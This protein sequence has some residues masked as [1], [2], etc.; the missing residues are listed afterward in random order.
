MKIKIRK[1]KETRNIGIRSVY[2]S[3]VDTYKATLLKGH[4]ITATHNGYCDTKREAIGRL[5]LENPK[6]FSISSITLI[7]E[8][9]SLKEEKTII[10]P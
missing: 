8:N 3:E 4:G 6:L 7:E 10:Y 2:W 9:P 1:S 5:L